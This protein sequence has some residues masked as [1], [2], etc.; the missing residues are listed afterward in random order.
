[1]RRLI[2]LVSALVAILAL[3]LVLFNATTIDRRPP[4]V[5]AITLS[6]PAG[7][8]HEA[9]TL[10]AIDIEFSEPVK[11]ATVEASFHIDPAVDGAFAFHGSTAIFTPSQKLPA[12]TSFTIRVDPGVQDLAGNVDQVGLD[13]WDFRTVGPPQVLRVTPADGTTGEPLDGTIELV[14]DRLMDTASVEAAITLDPSIPVSATWRGSVVTLAF[15]QGLHFGTT[16]TLTVGASAADTGGSRLGTPFTTRFTTVASGLRISKMVPAAGVA[17]VGVTSPVAIQFDGPINADTARSALHI[18]PSVDGEVRIVDLTDDPGPGSSPS[19][20]PDTLLFVP[21]SALA[22]HTTYTVTLDPTVA[23]VDDP[24]AVAAGRTWTFTTGAPT[25]SGQNQIAFLSARGGV[26]NVWVMNPDGTN[27][28]E[29]TSELAPVSSFDV[30]GDGRSIV[31]SSG[32]VVTVMAIDGSSVN[33]VTSDDGRHEYVPVFAPDDQHLVLARRDPAGS[34]LGYWLVPLPGT[35]G[36]ERQ[37]VDH[38]APALG[39]STVVGD[40]VG[41]ADGT[42]PWASRIAFD[43]TTGQALLV[44]AGGDV[45]LLDLGAGGPGGSPGQPIAIAL[46]ADAAPAWDAQ[47]GAFVVA[48]TSQGSPA[49]SLFAVR[50]DGTVNAIAGTDGAGGPVAIGPSGAAAYRA[51]DASGISTLRILGDDG[52]SR[53]LPAADGQVDRW[54]AFS[55]DG[56]TVLV[57]RTPIDLPSASDGV[58]LVEVGNGSSAQLSDDGAFARW[59]P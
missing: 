5:K 57:S 40:G 20:G 43:P 32:G 38:G 4:N 18:V 42:N 3:A 17:G 36:D 54:P 45:A 49:A 48:A 14:F 44:T 55:P 13:A 26:R 34:D 22:A 47:R 37:L 46:V 41:V 25:A 52:S 8:S 33:R 16:Y 35:G 27:Q 50:P 7:D 58:W 2:S 30:A 9:Q 31:Y 6:A 11:P 39:S 29:L 28:R 12:D 23:R 24:T 59:I 19:P 56:S 1:M 21:S 53:S 15:G 10:T 51:S